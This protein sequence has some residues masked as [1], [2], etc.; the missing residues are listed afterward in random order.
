MVSVSCAL[1]VAEEERSLRSISNKPGAFVHRTPEPTFLAKEREVLN[2]LD[3]P[4]HNGRLRLPRVIPFL[5]IQ[6]SLTGD[7]NHLRYTSY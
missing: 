1:N 4:A 3:L 5:L 7:N 2:E 6:L